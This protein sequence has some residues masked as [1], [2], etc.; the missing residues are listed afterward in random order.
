MGRMRVTRAATKIHKWV[1]LIVGVQVLLWFASGLFMA[2]YP[3]ETVRGEDRMR[4]G[5]PDLFAP[6]DVALRLARVL[7]E[8]LPPASRMEVRSVLGRPW[9]VIERPDQRPMLV[10]LEAGRIASPVPAALASEI[11]RADYSG[12]AAVKRVSLVEAESTEYRGAL[13]AWRVDFADGRSTSLYVAADLAR[14]T[15]RRTDL[16]RAYDF[17][18]GLHI[19][20]WKHH[21]D[22]NTWWL[23]LA[24]ALALVGAA[25]GLIM[26]PRSFGFLRKRDRFG[27][28]STAPTS[29]HKEA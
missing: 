3:I 6:A 26:L 14:V 17:L 16:W 25:A 12:D 27:A 19:M 2:H 20:D 9:L 23:W 15:A 28:P 10:D 7:P 11:A 5:P 4:E 24:S 22:F 1:V 18:W 21:E 29:P 13:P 8:G